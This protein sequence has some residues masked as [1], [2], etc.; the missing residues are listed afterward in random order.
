MGSLDDHPRRITKAERLPEPFSTIYTRALLNN[1]PCRLSIYAPALSSL[2]ARRPSDAGHLLM[3]FDNH[4]LVAR[5]PD[6]TDRADMFTVLFSELLFVEMGVILLYSWMKLVFNQQEHTE[7]K[8][9]FHT[10]GLGDFMEVLGFVRRALDPAPAQA[11]EPLSA[12]PE[13]PLKFQNALRHWLADGEAIIELAFQPEMRAHWLRFF[14]RQVA[15][16]LLVALTDRQ[17]LLITEEQSQW[18]TRAGR[19]GI[20]MSKYSSIYTYCPLSK[21]TSLEV[22]PAIEDGYANLC[23]TLMAE[24]A[25]SSSLDCERRFFAAVREALSE[26]E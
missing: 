11:C 21:V 9:P 6:A 26:S 18:K 4:L 16:P 19:E 23:V 25:F 7:I 24:S 12:W 8:I 3:V 15:P 1:G 13:L 20:G 17:L 5:Q 22:S 2:G 14:T 10:V